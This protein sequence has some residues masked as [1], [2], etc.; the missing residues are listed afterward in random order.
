MRSISPYADRSCS[1]S[2]GHERSAA[3]S[4]PHVATFSG[5]FNSPQPHYDSIA[6]QT[7][8]TTIMSSTR[9]PL[10]CSYPYTEQTERTNA[11]NEDAHSVT[12]WSIWDTA[13]WAA[14]TSFFTP[15]VSQ[16]S[17]SSSYTSLWQP[18]MFGNAYL[19]GVHQQEAVPS[20]SSYVPSWQY[21]PS[22]ETPVDKAFDPYGRSYYS[23]E[24]C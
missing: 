12:S 10:T 7:C 23:H 16:H 22:Q 14:D 18:S 20:T 8:D 2:V 24:P 1:G 5:T 15:N 9:Q 6:H 19:H 17:N 11:Y 13:P 4:S 3:S 21:Q